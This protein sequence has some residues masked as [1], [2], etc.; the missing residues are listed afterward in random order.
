M[1][2]ANAFLFSGRNQH[3]KITTVIY[4]LL[5]HLILRYGKRFGLDPLL[6]SISRRLPLTE[7]HSPLED[8]TITHRFALLYHTKP[9]QVHRPLQH[10]AL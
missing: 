4:L 7:T 3:A 5:R 1:S 9:A 6:Q 10:Y 8:W 2:N